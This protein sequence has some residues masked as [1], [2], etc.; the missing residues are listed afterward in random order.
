MND[1]KTSY[2]SGK[3]K[4]KKK[5]S[6]SIFEV[7]T[8]DELAKLRKLREEELEDFVSNKKK[9]KSIFN[10]FKSKK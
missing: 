1:S 9:N 7:S 6:F 4:H 5:V 3:S 10:K 8:F 2:D